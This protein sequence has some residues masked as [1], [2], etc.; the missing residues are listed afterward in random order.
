[1]IDNRTAPYGALVLRV[2]LGVMFLVHSLYLKL[3]VF[4]LPGTVKFFESLGLPGV[5]AHATVAVGAIDAARIGS[6]QRTLRSKRNR[7][8]IAM[9][10]DSSTGAA[11]ASSSAPVRVVPVNVSVVPASS[12]SRPSASAGSAPAAAVCGCNITRN[13]P[14]DSAVA[15]AAV[16]HARQPMAASST[17]RFRSGDIPDA[18]L[19]RGH[20]PFGLVALMLQF[21]CQYSPWYAVSIR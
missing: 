5:A 18:P 1:M 15:V 9:A 16:P 6:A 12:A 11:R 8:T 10:S 2:S 17:Q 4:T 20:G 3:V 19:V 14:T 13:L 7:L 21:R